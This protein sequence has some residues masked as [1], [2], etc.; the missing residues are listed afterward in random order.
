MHTKYSPID[1]NSTAGFYEEYYNQQHGNGLAVFKGKRHMDGAGIGSVLGSL[2]KAVG[3]SIARIGKSAARSVGRHAM[4]VARDVLA[5]EDLQTSALRN[6]KTGGVEVL[7][8]IMDSPAPS[9]KRKR[10]SGTAKNGKRQKRG[11][12]FE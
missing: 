10:T 8:D 12:I 9:R 2:F 7:N 11:T 6:L 1:L 3:P 5:G 4:N